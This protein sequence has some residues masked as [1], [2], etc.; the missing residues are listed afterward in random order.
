MNISIEDRLINLFAIT[1]VF[2]KRLFTANDPLHCSQTTTHK[3]Q[4]CTEFIRTLFAK[5][6]LPITEHKVEPNNRGNN[7]EL[8]NRLLLLSESNAI[9]SC[10]LSILRAPLEHAQAHSR[11]YDS[12]QKTT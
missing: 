2:I 10:S 9:T 12:V 1:S 7:S 5:D 8:A 4:R 11:D 3:R 6:L